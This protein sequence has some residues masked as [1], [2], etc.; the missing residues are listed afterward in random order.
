MPVKSDYFSRH[1][2][3]AIKIA[4]EFKHKLNKIHIQVWEV[5][6]CVFKKEI[7]RKLEML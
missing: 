7:L 6:K 5:K 3:F 4:S 1:N 2:I